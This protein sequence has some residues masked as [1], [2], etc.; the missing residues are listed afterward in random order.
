[1]DIMETLVC[2][3]SRAYAQPMFAVAAITGERRQWLALKAVA[4]T[5]VQFFEIFRQPF[6]PELTIRLPE[7]AARQIAKLV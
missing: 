1:M 3:D 7:P 6:Y 4:G 2:R 5:A